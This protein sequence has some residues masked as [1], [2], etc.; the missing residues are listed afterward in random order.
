MSLRQKIWGITF[1]FLAVVFLAGWGAN[2]VG[3]HFY[4][5]R[6]HQ[7]FSAWEKLTG[8]EKHLTYEEWESVIRVTRS[9]QKYP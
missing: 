8:N 2:C 5:E 1:A 4:E 6:M 3:Q 9:T 7:S